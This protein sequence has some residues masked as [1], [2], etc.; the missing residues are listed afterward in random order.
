MCRGRGFSGRSGVL[1]G[2]L[3]GKGRRHMECACYFAD[4]GISGH[5]HWGG[6]VVWVTFASMLGN[7]FEL[8]DP[9]PTQGEPFR[10]AGPR[11]LERVG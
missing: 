1:I 11:F 5:E 8:G 3:V 2:C 6:G 10:R 4:S 9:R 7:S